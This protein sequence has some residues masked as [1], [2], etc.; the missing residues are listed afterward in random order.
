MTVNGGS[1]ADTYRTNYRYA[2]CSSLNQL[3]NHHHPFRINRNTN[4]VTAT[5]TTNAP[6][7]R[8]TASLLRVWGS[9]FTRRD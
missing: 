7:S 3:R 8:Y 2:T 1:H 4:T 9:S 5:K 6:I